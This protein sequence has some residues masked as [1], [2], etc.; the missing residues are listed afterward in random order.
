MKNKYS[1]DGDYLLS[2]PHNFDEYR[3]LVVSLEANTKQLNEFHLRMIQ[4]FI[5]RVGS[6]TQPDKWVMEALADNFLKVVMGGRWEDEFPLP[7]TQASSPFSRAEKSALNI[8][9]DIANALKANPK[10]KVTDAI[11]K[12]AGEHF[13]SYEKARAAYYSYKK[14]FSKNEPKT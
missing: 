7:W 10:L 14:V 13:V 12:I 11:N 5:E 3:Q 9:C 2:E 8:Y 4:H 1:N 6:E